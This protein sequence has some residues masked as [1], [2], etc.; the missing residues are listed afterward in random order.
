MSFLSRIFTWW[1]SCTIGTGFFTWLHGTSVGADDQGNRYYSD[2]DG[3][4]RWV[5][6]NGEMEASR[7]P[8]DWHRWLHHTAA[9]PPTIR[10]LVTKPWE[11]PHQANLTGS[12]GAYFPPGSMNAIGK[13]APA[14]G[15]YEAWKPEA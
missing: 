6:Y 1:N 11:R 15:D 14:T 12:E 4:R 2:K 5:I 9:E 3:A 13:R 10:P 8:P 7:I